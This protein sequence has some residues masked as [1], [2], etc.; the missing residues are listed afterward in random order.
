MHGLFVRS[1]AFSL[2]GRRVLSGSADGAARLWDA[3]T[4]EGLGRELKHGDAVL[5]VAFGLDGNVLTR[6]EGFVRLWDPAT[7][8]G[9]LPRFG[10]PDRLPPRE[11]R[12]P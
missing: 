7:R 1:V 8:A 4:R 9:G 11:R 12:P 2:D 3:P 10:S 5:G 6:T